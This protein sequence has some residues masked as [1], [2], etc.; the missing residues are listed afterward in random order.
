MPEPRKTPWWRV[1]LILGIPVA[2]IAWW[3]PMTCNA[4]AWVPSRECK[5]I[6]PWDQHGPHIKDVTTDGR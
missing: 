2:L 5:P 6:F 3:N 1:A 4:K